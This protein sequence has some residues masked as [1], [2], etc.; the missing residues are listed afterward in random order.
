[1]EVTLQVVIHILVQ[2]IQSEVVLEDVQL[3]IDTARVEGLK[4]RAFPEGNK[5]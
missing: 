1:M 4:E 5:R 2:C 3:G